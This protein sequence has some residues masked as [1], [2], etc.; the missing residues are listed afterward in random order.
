MCVKTKH[1]RAHSPFSFL[2]LSINVFDITCAT[3]FICHNA[4]HCLP[5]DIKSILI[6]LIVISRFVLVHFFFAVALY[7]GYLYD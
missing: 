3:E 6:R 7:E 1:I 5:P 4:I 2:L